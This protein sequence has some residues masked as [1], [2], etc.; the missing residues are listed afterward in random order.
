MAAIEIAQDATQVVHDLTVISMF[1]QKN[2]TFCGWCSAFRRCG[3]E[4]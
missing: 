1:L 2:D 3:R 4:T